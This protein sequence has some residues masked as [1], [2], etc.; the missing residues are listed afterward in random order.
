VNG[1]QN[2][3]E[4][5]RQSNGGKPGLV[6]FHRFFSVFGY[7]VF[8]FA[9]ILGVLEGG[10]WLAWKVYQKLRSPSQALKL[11][12]EGPANHDTL[13]RIRNPRGGQ[14]NWT[15][16]DVWTE[17]M[18]GGAAYEKWI[19]QMSASTAYDKT[20]WADEFWTLERQRLAHW[21]YPY[22]PFRVWGMM[23]W[24][25]KYVNNLQTELGVLR[26]TVSAANPAC[27]QHSPTRV[28]ILGGSTV[29]GV[30]TPDSETVPSQLARQVN[31]AGGN[32]I[33]VTNLGVEA[34]VS[35]QELLFL[36]QHLKAGHRPDIV[37][38]YD[39]LNDACV[40]GVGGSPGGHNYL[41][42]IKTAF[43]TGGSVAGTLAQESNFLRLV[44]ALRRRIESSSKET[45]LS[46]Q[47]KATLDNYEANIAIARML[48]EKYGFKTWF[49]WQPTLIYG[50]KPLD[51]F[52]QVLFDEVVSQNAG[53]PE[54]ETFLAVR[55]VY[56]EA[57]RR[58][59]ASGNVVFLGH[60]FDDVRE[61]IYIDWMHLGPRGNE[62]VAAAIAAKL[63]STLLSPEK[64]SP[65][66]S[67]E[68]GQSA[69]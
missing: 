10:S 66:G 27:S 19:D 26:R 60:M 61:P 2:H 3:G 44:R 46:P 7:A 35:N 18:G 11:K 43:E 53:Q 40:G 39:G 34:Y 67:K 33:E 13:A 30:G 20:D 69:H 24:E 4:T 49:F 1:P 37:I 12:S 68:K 22:E 28:W 36:I 14:L 9:L 15:S 29:W 65:A 63:H 6:P 45:D 31:A 21:S 42:P 57:E 38:F 59:R 16:D 17:R 52:E 50:K 47:A 48:G 5:M 25:G 51:P 54:S 55:A 64:T 32:C 56:E 41:L 8:C 62:I 23:K 58:S